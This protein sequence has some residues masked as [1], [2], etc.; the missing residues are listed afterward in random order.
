MGFPLSEG[1][2]RGN[3]GF[4]EPKLDAH[5]VICITTDQVINILHA[6]WDESQAQKVSPLSLEIWATLLGEGIF[7]TEGKLQASLWPT[8]YMSVRGHGH[9]TKVA[10]QNRTA[11]GNRESQ[12]SV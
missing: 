5:Y 3:T 2:G 9:L 6:K 4:W 11:P 1:V 8:A 12:P 10:P 7:L